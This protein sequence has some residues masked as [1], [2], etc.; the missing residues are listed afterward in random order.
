MDRD[1]GRDEYGIARRN[2]HGF[3]AGPQIHAVRA[4]RGIRRQMLTYT[5]I[6]NLELNGRFLHASR[7][8]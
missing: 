5:F 4:G 7:I 6:E 8:Y 2:G 1:A 3:A